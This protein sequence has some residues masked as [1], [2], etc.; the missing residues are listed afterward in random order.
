MHGQISNAAGIPLS[1][2]TVKIKN[3]NISTTSNQ[4]GQFELTSPQ[5]S[6]TLAVSFLGYETLEI[7]VSEESATI[8]LKPSNTSLSEVDVTINT[9]Y[10]TIAK[11]RA[12]GAFSSLP[13]N[14]LQQQ[15]LNNLG[16]LLEGRIAGYHNGLLR[17]TTSMRGVT[18][19]LYVIDGFPVDNTSMDFNGNVVENLLTSIWKI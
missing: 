2:A 15:R 11:E 13:K 16:S 1:G 19:P 12:T 17:G 3:T 6:A 9:G 10:Q 8:V 5:R 7:N 18:L 4:N 14:S